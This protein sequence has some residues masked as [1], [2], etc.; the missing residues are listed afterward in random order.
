VLYNIRPES[1]IDF[2]ELRGDMDV[3]SG[4]ATGKKPSSKRRATRTARLLALPGAQLDAQ[5]VGALLAEWRHGELRLA[6]SYRQCR[7]V[8]AEQLE[9][10]Y[11]DTSLV[12][13][14]RGYSDQEHLR[15]A[16][17]KGIKNRA[18]QLHRDEHTRREILKRTAPDLF[19][20]RDT[21][22]I[23]NPP[24]LA[25]LLHQD[26]AVVREFLTELTEA[27]KQ[28]FVLMADGMRHRSIAPTLGLPLNEARK[29]VRVC[30]RKRERFQLLYDTG[31]LCGFRS[32]TIL[33]MQDGRATSDELAEQAFAHLEGCAHCRAEHKTNARRLRRTFQGQ[34]AALLPFPALAGHLGWV[35]RL[36]LRVRSVQ[37]RL[38][39]GGSPA[40]GGVRE[41][42]VQLLAGGGVAA[43]VA[44]GVATV[45]VIAGGTIGA[46]RVLEHTPAHHQAPRHA[47]V[48][49]LPAAAAAPPDQPSRSTLRAIAQTE[50]RRRAI[51]RERP[52][53]R[54]A[55]SGTASQSSGEQREPGGFAYLGVPTTTAA[56]PPAETAHVASQSGGGPFSP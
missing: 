19:A 20:V 35:T 5:L 48:A 43:K 4:E 23:E 21:G 47:I 10:I 49:S 22:G 6:R 3:L 9:D 15:N 41:R 13:L 8:S 51:P 29:I 52:S 28:V 33:A 45:A 46:T 17:R 55:T 16:L 12:L 26:R 42:T 36:D 34:A 40:G 50:P 24:E 25:A 14:R 7:G 18:L 31:R 56:A 27:E 30:E 11:Q 32:S 39:P 2:K 1:R 38:M 44:A 53:P 54:P 37:Q